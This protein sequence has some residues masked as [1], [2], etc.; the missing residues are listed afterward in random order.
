MLTE[1]DTQRVKLAKAW[2]KEAQRGSVRQSP[3]A[4]P[5]LMDR[6]PE[7]HLDS[8]PNWKSREVY[9]QIARIC[10]FRSQGLSEDE[11]AQEARFS[12][13]D[14]MYFRLKRWGLSGLVPLEKETHLDSEP[15]Q[16][17]VAQDES[18][19]PK[20]RTSGKVE[21]LPSARNAMPLFREVLEGLLRANEELKYRKDTRQGKHYPY[22]TVSP[23]TP[24]DEEWDYFADLFGFDPI[25]RNYLYFGGTE[26]KYGASS[27]APLS[28]LAELIGTYLLAGGDVELLVEALHP[29]SSEANWSEITRYIEG[30][31]GSS[32]Q[33]DGI[34]SMA[35]RLAI[36]ICGGTLDRGQPPPEVPGHDLNLSDRIAAGLKAGVPRERLHQELLAKLGLSEEEFPWSE[37]CRLADL[38]LELPRRPK[39]SPEEP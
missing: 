27:R 29:S 33:Q 36:L 23:K 4:T 30:R 37:F 32:R 22:R 21:D 18:K 7:Q 14:D 1:N 17:A 13:V 16:E 35:L 39:R 19:A 3:M 31:K 10:A 25:A 12:S 20:A 6:L 24:S 28:P 34:K 15:Q 2:R 11:V 26:I 5:Q 38:G 8:L 9:L